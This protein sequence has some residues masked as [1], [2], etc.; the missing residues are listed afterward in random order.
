[1]RFRDYIES[2]ASMGEE[3]DDIVKTLS[4]LPPS[5][6]NRVKG[7]DWK[8]QGGN[9]LSGDQ[10][11]VGYMD[12][13]EKEI[14]VAAP[15]NYGREFTALHEIAH[16]IWESLPPEVQK[17][18]FHV[19]KNTKPSADGQNNDS[20]NQNPEELFCMSYACYYAKHKIV[21][22]YKPEWMNF[23]KNLPQ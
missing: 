17:Q 13:Q 14:A 5:H 4:K 21:T 9:T 7:F 6:R 10:Q 11:H 23:I 20:L 8:F 3:K 1:M 19:V 12:S 22:Y 15:W 2:D 16:T 18:W